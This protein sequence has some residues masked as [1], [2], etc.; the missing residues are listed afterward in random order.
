MRNFFFV[1]TKSFR[2]RKKNRSSSDVV[3]TYFLKFHVSNQTLSL[4]WNVWIFE[5]I[6]VTLEL[7]TMKTHER[8]ANIALAGNFCTMWALSAR[9]AK[10]C[11]IFVV[12]CDF[13]H[14]LLIRSL[15]LLKKFSLV[16]LL[17]AQQYVLCT[18]VCQKYN[19]TLIINSW[20]LVNVHHNIDILCAFTFLLPL[21]CSMRSVHI[22]TY[23]LR[24]FICHVAVKPNEFFPYLI[25][26]QFWRIFY[27][28]FLPKTNHFTYKF[29]FSPRT[30]W[31]GLMVE[32]AHF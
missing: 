11:W 3:W 25:L 13:S 26:Y 16:G 5:I 10:S 28:F 20:L 24:S 12:F 4:V 2:L 23:T 31:F 9:S 21:L 6:G 8:A 17:T 15:F 22:L 32:R 30:R 7:M 18:N 29:M 27:L 14:W 1:T 19:Y